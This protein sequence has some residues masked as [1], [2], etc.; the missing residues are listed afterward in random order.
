MSKRTEHPL[1]EQ[2][3]QLAS[4]SQ[5]QPTADVGVTPPLTQV[6]AEPVK[7]STMFLEHS[8]Q[9]FQTFA[10]LHAIHAHQCAFHRYHDDPSRHVISHHYCSHITEDVMQC[11]IYDGYDT[12]SAKLIGI[13]YIIGSRVFATLPDEEKQYWHPH[14]YEIK[15]GLLT[16][17]GVPMMAE[18]RIMERLI[19]TYGKTWHT[20]QVD[21][22][23]TL[24]IGPAKLM[25]SYYKPEDVDWAVVQ[26]RDSI[27]KMDTQ[28]LA[29]HRATM[30]H[31]PIDPKATA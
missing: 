18:D 19:N 6:M 25:S 3:S 20:W 22:G 30:A 9:A 23:D 12:R 1:S 21:R 26:R 16:V 11:V 7:T 15:S 29:Q 4:Q 27:L 13:E 28:K 8:G 17:P 5:Q 10:P 31:G 24:P 14:V 2:S